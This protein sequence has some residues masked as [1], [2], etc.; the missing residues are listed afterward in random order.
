MNFRHT[1][2]ALTISTI[3]AHAGTILLYAAD[4]D[5]NA[6]TPAPDM[7]S[8]GWSLVNLD[9]QTPGTAFSTTGSTNGGAPAWILNDTSFPTGTGPGQSNAMVYDIDSA[10][11]GQLDIAGF[12]LTINLEQLNS[13]SFVGVGLN[14]DTVDLFNVGTPDR[15]YGQTPASGLQTIT[16]RF[17][18]TT[19]TPN[20][21]AGTSTSGGATSNFW[22]GPED[23]GF[24][25]FMGDNTRNGSNFNL[26]ITSVTLE[27]SAIPEPSS[28]TLLGLAG[29]GLL[30]CRR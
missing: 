2:W 30:R 20:T 18:G 28:A 19:F 29:L 21:G 27:S 15:R 22:V 12:T 13:G 3:A 25:I 16:Y 26:A 6:G 10:L 14:N 7:T 11:A 5:S 9:G 8:Q 4:P 1:L 23:G 17:D 24:R